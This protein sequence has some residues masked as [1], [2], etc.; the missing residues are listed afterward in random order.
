MARGWN[1]EPLHR[2]ISRHAI[3]LSRGFSILQILLAAPED[4]FT[5]GKTRIGV[6]VLREKNT[7]SI[8]LQDTLE[9]TSLSSNTLGQAF[10]WT[11]LLAT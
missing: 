8:P 10:R 1:S 4:D 2:S 7:T 9:E 5:L 3:D 6:S 11:V